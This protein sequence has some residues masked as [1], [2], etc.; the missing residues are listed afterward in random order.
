[1]PNRIITSILFATVATAAT[2]ANTEFTDSLKTPELNNQNVTA[3]NCAHRLFTTSK[4]FDMIASLQYFNKIKERPQ[5]SHL[6]ADSAFMSEL[7]T[8]NDNVSASKLCNLYASFGG[9]R[10]DTDSCVVFFTLL[11]E[12]N[13]V[14]KY[15][16]SWVNNI[17]NLSP[18]ISSCLSAINNA[19]YSEYWVS[20]IKPVI[21]GYINSYPVSEKALN[22]IHDAMTEFSGPEILPPTHSNIY[23]LNI[24]NAFNLSDESFCCTPI[25][26]NTEFEK[27]FRLDFLKVYIH[28]NL[29]RLS[30]S[31]ELMNRLDELMADDFYHENENVARSHNEGRNEAFVVAAEVFIS[32][33]I[34]RRDNRSVYNEFKEYVDGSLVLAPI[35]YI[36]LHD[37]QEAE[38]LNDFILRLFDNGTIKTGYVKTAYDKAMSRLETAIPQT[39]I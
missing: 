10:H 6:A 39:E 4:S 9:N 24:D 27:K 33:K 28:E 26:L 1:M 34:G 15:D 3:T 2:V 30:I 38:S 11:A 25:L 18:Q 21:D 5:F 16:E 12:N 22:A 20:D 35:I 19:G 13:D 23:I 31:G 14:I 29:H 37:K 7:N 36:H 32:H 8:I 17:V